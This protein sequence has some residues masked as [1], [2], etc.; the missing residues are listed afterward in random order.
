MSDPCQ[1]DESVLLD[2]IVGDASPA[3]R[4]AIEASPP[5]RVAAEALRQALGSLM[6]IVYRAACPDVET[7]V[8]YQERR[9]DSTGQLVMRKHVGGCPLCQHELQLLASIDA[10][11]LWPQPS[12]PRRV[13]EALFRP[14]L[15]RAQPVRGQSLLFQADELMIHLSVYAQP[16]AAGRWVVRGHVR[17]PDGLRAAEVVEEVGAER[18]DEPTPM[19]VV[20]AGD[21]GAFRIAGLE[22]GTY[23]VSLVLAGVEIV[24][25]GLAV[26]ADE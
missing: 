23:D 2:Y 9:L 15:A 21:P 10:V 26:P 6:G 14:P 8:A 25:R 1:F 20:G 11:P 17:S 22:R 16:G 13:I 4:S 12:G 3:V 18:V 5:C 19:S 7:L 24:V